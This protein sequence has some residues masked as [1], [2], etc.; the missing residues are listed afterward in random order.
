MELTIHDLA[1]K[2]GLSRRTIH[3]YA[4]EG[5]IPSPRG[6]GPSA[7]YGE[8]HLLRLRLIPCL[9]SAGLR[10]DRIACALEALSREEMRRLVREAPSAGLDD[11]VALA[12]WIQD[13]RG[14]SGSWCCRR[15]RPGLE[16]RYRTDRGADFEAK[17]DELSRLARELFEE[18]A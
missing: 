15:L 14:V 5:L 16:I 7:T 18:E 13:A 4:H 17:I 2:S 1:Q 10:L 6:N 9:K 11:P 3:Y 12:E 8:E